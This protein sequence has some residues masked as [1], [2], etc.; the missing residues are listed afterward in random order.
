MGKKEQERRGRK[1]RYNNKRTSISVSGVCVSDAL[2][3]GVVR[4]EA[5]P[6][7]TPDQVGGDENGT[8]GESGWSQQ[9][10]FVYE[11]VVIYLALFGACLV[12]LGFCLLACRY[13]SLFK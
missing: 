3:L 12:F 4:T 8:S 6:A 11:L 10:R 2:V 1:S 5:M 9:V 7:L 13:L